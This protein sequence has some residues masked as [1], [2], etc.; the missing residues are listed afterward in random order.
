MGF[1]LVKIAP[2]GQFFIGQRGVEEET[3]KV[4]YHQY[5]EMA[6]DTKHVFV[7]GEVPFAQVEKGLLHTNAMDIDFGGGEH[8]IGSECDGG[9][10]ADIKSLLVGATAEE[11]EHENT[12]DAGG[13][14]GVER[15]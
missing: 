7:V 14:D 6:I 13:E 12:H 1:P 10:D 8:G 11:T 4:A 2:D 5:D 9:G 3:G 15:K